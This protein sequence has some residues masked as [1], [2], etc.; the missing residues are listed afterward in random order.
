MTAHASLFRSGKRL[1]RAAVNYTGYDIRRLPDGSSP[2]VDVDCPVRVDPENGNGAKGWLVE[3]VGPSGVGKSTLFDI[4]LAGRKPEDGWLTPAESLRV[5]K[6][7][8]FPVQLDDTYERLLWL[9]LREVSQSNHAPSVKYELLAFFNGNLRLDASLSRLELKAPVVHHDGLLHNF[10][11]CFALLRK[12]D[13]IG[14]SRLIKNRAIVHCFAPAQL[15]A[16][17]I[18]KRNDEGYA[19]PQHRNLSEQELIEQST[20]V[21]QRE[22]GL[23]A[24]LKEEGAPCLELNLAHEPDQNIEA[25]QRFIDSLGVYGRAETP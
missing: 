3:F 15:I 22:S 9:K 7:Q 19:R 21:L 20:V 6:P 10:S 14:F 1:L 17:R 24:L 23:V 2:T 5:F 8:A 25:I 16:D 13:P 4:M 12:D 11:P 18:L